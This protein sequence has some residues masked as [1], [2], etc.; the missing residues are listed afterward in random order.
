MQANAAWWEIL[1][2]GLGEFAGKFLNWFG[3]AGFVQPMEIKDTLTGSSVSVRVSGYFTV[4]TIDGREFYFKR[5]TGA[6]DGSGM[7]VNQP[8]VRPVADSLRG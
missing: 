3:V 1:R 8:I 4:I 6:Y 5:L 2:E 7:S